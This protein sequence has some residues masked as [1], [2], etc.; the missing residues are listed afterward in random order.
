MNKDESSENSDWKFYDW[1]CWIWLVMINGGHILFLVNSW[2]IAVNP[3]KYSQKVK[4]FNTNI[5]PHRKCVM[6][7]YRAVR[8][9]NSLQLVILQSVFPSVS[10]IIVR[11]FTQTITK[12][13]CGKCNSSYMKVIIKKT[14]THCWLVWIFTLKKKVITVFMDL[15]TSLMYQLKIAGA[16]MRTCQEADLESGLQCLN[17]DANVYT[18]F[19]LVRESRR[20]LRHPLLS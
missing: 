20:Q 18:E 12:H 6:R 9:L 7:Y 10:G 14:C 19:C 2:V 13:P 4:G 15:V 8:N 11:F 5:N 1:T 16:K 3:W 17:N